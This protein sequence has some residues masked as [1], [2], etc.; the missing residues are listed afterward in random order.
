MD[1]TSSTQP[2]GGKSK[3]TTCAVDRDDTAYM[4]VDRVLRLSTES[5]RSVPTELRKRKKIH[6]SKDSKEHCTVFPYIAVLN[7]P[8]FT[9]SPNLKAVHN[10]P[11]CLLLF[12]HLNNASK[13][14]N[15]RNL[16]QELSCPSPWNICLHFLKIMK[17]RHFP[18]VHRFMEISLEID[19]TWKVSPKCMS[20]NADSVGFKLKCNVHLWA[21]FEK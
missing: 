1:K 16:M 2:H 19:L 8:K 5:I 6:C 9:P 15:L 4:A 13:S 11:E 7:T 17:L 10:D 20:A 18:K 3:G 14:Q 12:Y 21:Y